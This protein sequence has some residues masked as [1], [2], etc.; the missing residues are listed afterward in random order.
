[1]TG[2]MNV[3]GFAT[4]SDATVFSSD[5]LDFNWYN[6]LVGLGWNQITPLS[7]SITINAGVYVYSD[8]VGGY[9]FDQGTIFP[10]GSVAQIIIPGFIHGKGGAGAAGGFGT[11]PNGSVGGPALN[12]LG[13]TGGALIIITGAGVIAGGGGGGGAGGAGFSGGP[14]VGGNAGG[15][16]ARSGGAGGNNG[17]STPGGA[18]TSSAG[19]AGQAGGPGAGN[20]GNGGAPGVAGLTGGL[21][22]L[23]PGGTGGGPGLGVQGFS[24]GDFSGF[25]GSILGGTAG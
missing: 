9:G 8:T 1:M 17:L 7:V 2:A 18:G 5:Q 24:L 4:F 23:S 14:T 22:S 21:G 19:G 6:Y 20:G 25:S 12:L 3:M 13:I 10:A 16:G 15:G 11:G